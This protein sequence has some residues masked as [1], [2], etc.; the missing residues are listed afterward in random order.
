M[1]E[2]P[3]A[4][5]LTQSGVKPILLET[6]VIISASISGGVHSPTMLP[7]VPRNHDAIL[8]A[9]LD[10]IDAGATIVSIHGRQGPDGVPGRSD[11]LG[12]V[13]NSIRRASNAIIAL[14]GAAGQE[15]S[16][17]RVAAVKSVIPDMAGVPLGSFN[18]WTYPIASM[19]PKWEMSWEIRN[20]G[21]NP[22]GMLPDNLR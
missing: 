18:R 1:P 14:T 8:T 5:G 20:F 4:L 6:P 16:D 22:L 9:A 7:A 12:P 19:F 2:P 3:N 11:L 10:A 15:A 21:A 13:A 17:E